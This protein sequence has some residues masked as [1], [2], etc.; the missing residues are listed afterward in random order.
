MDQDSKCEQRIILLGRIVTNQVPICITNENT[1]LPVASIG[2]LH[3]S[4]FINSYYSSAGMDKRKCGRIWYN[5]IHP[6]Q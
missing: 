3:V 5:S 4:S 6:R 1:N 2:M